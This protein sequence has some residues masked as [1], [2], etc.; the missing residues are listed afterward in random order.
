MDYVYICRRGENE[1]LR[2]SLRS[3]EKNMPAG[4][5]WLVGYR[6]EWYVGNFIQV[7]NISDTDKFINIK[8]CIKEILNNNL[9]KEDFVLMNDDFFALKEINSIKNF[10]G[11]LLED[12]IIEYKKLGRSSRYI[13]LLELTLKQLKQN[14]IDDP[15][16]YDIHVPMLIKKSLLKKVIDLAYFPR[17]TYGNFAQLERNT[18]IDVKMYESDNAITYTKNKSLEFISTEDNS[19][20]SLKKHILSKEFINISKCE[21]PVYSRVP[22]GI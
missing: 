10:D 21:N 15:L 20:R 4:D 7:E 5:V 12:K 18:I 22:N 17:S 19:F 11:G 14:G 16:D 9:I 8:N 3:L 2:Y 6:P 1:E 13:K